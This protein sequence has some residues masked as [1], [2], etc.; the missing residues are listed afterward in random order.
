MLLRRRVDALLVCPWT[1]DVVRRGL[2]SAARYVRLL[3]VDR[4]TI[5]EADFVGVDQLAGMSEIVEHLRSCGAESAVFAGR[6]EG[7]SSIVERAEA[8]ETACE[9]LGVEAWPTVSLDVPNVLAGREFAR[10]LI[11]GRK[12]PSAVA[13]A[14]DEVAF[15]VLGRA[16]GGRDRLPCGGGRDRLRRHPRSGADGADNRPPAPPRAGPGGGSAT[17]A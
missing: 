12:L 2:R 4:W 11:S 16:P 15:G 10:K 5:E 13:C 8:F 1:L 3:Q 17:S 6:H 7:M 9:K 14:N